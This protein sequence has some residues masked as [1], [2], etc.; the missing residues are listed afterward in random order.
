MTANEARQTTKRCSSFIAYLITDNKNEQQ[1]S[2][3]M[4]I[5]ALCAVL[6]PDGHSLVQNYLEY[7]GAIG[8]SP[9]TILHNVE[10][11]RHLASFAYRNM[12][13]C[14][15]RS[16]NLPSLLSYLAELGCKVTI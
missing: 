4:V 1:I 14:S 8:Y 3:Y 10:Y 12:R 9:A 2:K 16:S 7:L 11:I 13:E 15:R 6:R 5:G